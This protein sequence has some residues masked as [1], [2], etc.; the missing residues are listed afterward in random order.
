MCDRASVAID[1]VNV[2]SEYKEELH[3]IANDYYII[4]SKYLNSFQS[5]LGVQQWTYYRA[6][7]VITL[8]R[9]LK[10]LVSHDFRPHWK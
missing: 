9:L 5:I 1:K 2:C 10:V 6:E 3:E 8:C 4:I 7:T